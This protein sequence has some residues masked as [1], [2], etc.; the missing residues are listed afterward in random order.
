MNNV[1]MIKEDLLSCQTKQELTA[2][3]KQY[4]LIVEKLY[5]NT[6]TYDEKVKLREIANCESI[7]FYDLLNTISEYLKNKLNLT[8]VK[9][10]KQ[11]II[12]HFKQ[13][14]GEDQS[15]RIF[16]L[17]PQYE[18]IWLSLLHIARYNQNI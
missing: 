10:R 3:R 17:D 5:E 8:E 12:N 1:L 15:W 11:W 2:I 6:L 18:S 14:T 9:Q 13:Q 7:D 4:P 16:A